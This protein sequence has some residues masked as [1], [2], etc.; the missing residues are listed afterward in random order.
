MSLTTNSPTGED[1]ARIDS[2]VS[3]IDAEISFGIENGSIG[4]SKLSE[5][6]GAQELAHAEQKRIHDAYAKASAEAARALADKTAEDV[7]TS[8]ASERANVIAALLSASDAIGTLCDALTH[9]EAARR[10]NAADLNVYGDSDRVR[11]TVTGVSL[12]GRPL[13]KPVVSPT[14]ADLLRAVIP[15]V[16]LSSDYGAVADQLAG[17]VRFAPSLTPQ[18]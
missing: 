1:V 10:Q 13:L 11:H 5:L 8:Q 2:V 12:D 6:R 14:V 17:A 7:L 16:R 9:A 3:E 4:G 15:L 18:R